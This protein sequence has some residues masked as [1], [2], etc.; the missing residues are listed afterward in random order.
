MKRK[1][2]SLILCF[3]MLAACFLFTSCGSDDG[4]NSDNDANVDSSRTPASLSFYIITDDS[5]TPE[6][7]KSM[8]EAFNDY[9]ESHFSTHVEFTM[10]KES[11][12]EA[13]LA[14]HW[15]KVRN[16]P[17]QS[18][19]TK[20]E[21]YV[22]S[23]GMTRIKYPDI[24]SDQLDIVLITSK[25][26]L[27]SNIN[28]LEKLDDLISTSYPD[29]L[30]QF[31]KSF[32]DKAKM[33]A[34]GDAVA[35]VYAIPNNHV[36]GTYTYMFIK[37]EYANNLYM[38]TVTGNGFKNYK[39]FYSFASE[40]NSAYTDVAPV[41]NAFSHPSY[42]YVS[43][44][45]SL[46]FLAIESRSTGFMISNMLENLSSDYWNYY[47]LQ[48]PGNIYNEST[49]KDYA[50]EVVQGNYQLRYNYPESEY[51][52][53]ILKVPTFTDDDIF[54]SMF[55]ITKN[56]KNKERA[57]EIINAINTNSDLHN[58]LLYG[59]E[60]TNFELSG[61]KVATKIAG[62][63]G[64]G[65]NIYSMNPKYTGNIFVSYVNDSMEELKPGFAENGKKQNAD[66]EYTTSSSWYSK[67]S[68]SGANNITD[69]VKAMLSDPTIEKYT[70]LIDYI[71]AK[72]TAPMLA[73]LEAASVSDY[74][75]ILRKYSDMV[76]EGG[77][78][79]NDVTQLRS[80]LRPFLNA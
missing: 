9:T 67:F 23:L 13:K 75:A 14:E 62:K 46:S 24:L 68:E 65:D 7:I 80:A 58:I 19:P 56:S 69:N 53:N 64:S 15:A 77:I 51:I 34:A 66:A 25:K 36:L 78:Y 37:K 61:T 32:I 39:D 28:N 33:K 29:M 79:Y 18:V 8:Q 44:D 57:L 49:D 41:K 12:Y 70:D 74:D 22:D 55:A 16:A 50:M 45:G 20:F 35:S 3:S 52:C 60:G 63:G 10:L 17:A 59:K 73:E 27:E 2:L 30:T 11:E 26:M 38:D 21:T 43:S 72:I 48:L 40:I 31:N 6:G 54:S 4:D 76:K 47:K 5:T 71:N 1:I 42:N